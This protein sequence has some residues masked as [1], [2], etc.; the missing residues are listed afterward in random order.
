[1]KDILLTIGKIAICILIIILIITYAFYHTDDTASNEKEVVATSE[2]YRDYEVI[3][4]DSCEYIRGYRTL[5]YR[6]AHKGNCKFCK[7]R[8]QKELED[9]VYKLK[10]ES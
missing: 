8:R 4:I 1:M 3:I 6:L 7:E 5:D 2:V 9:L 10:E